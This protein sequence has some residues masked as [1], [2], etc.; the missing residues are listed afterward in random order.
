M[1]VL[2]RSMAGKD[3]GDVEDNGCLFEGKRILRGRFMCEG[4]EPKS[5]SVRSFVPIYAD[6]SVCGGGWPVFDACL[7]SEANFNVILVDGKP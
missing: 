2:V 1:P 4:I 5:E 3:G 7:P 6:R